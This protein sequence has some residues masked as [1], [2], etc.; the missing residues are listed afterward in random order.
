MLGKTFLKNNQKSGVSVNVYLDKNKSQQIAT[1]NKNPTNSTDFISFQGL[2]RT[3]E[4]SSKSGTLT[5]ECH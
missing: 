1:Q 2:S 5:L 3:L 4:Q